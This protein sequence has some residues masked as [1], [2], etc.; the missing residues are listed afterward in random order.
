[1]DPVITTY[2]LLTLS[3]GDALSLQLYRFKGATPGKVVYLQSNLH[4]AEIAGNVV[5]HHLVTYLQTLD[6]QKLQG[7][8][9]LVPSCN[10]LG[11]NTRAHQFSSGRFNPYDGRDWNRIFWDYEHLHQGALPFAQQ[12]LKQDIATIQQAYRQTILEHFQTQLE[13]L[14]S[15]VGVPVHQA[16]RT[17]LQH[18]ALDADIVIDLHTSANQGMV[19]L[20]YFRDRAA[21]IPTFGVDFALML[22]HYDGN[23]FDEAFINPWLSLETAFASLGRPLQFEIDAWTLELGC[24]L[25]INPVAVQRGV[26]GVLNYLRYRGI[27]TDQPAITHPPVPLGCRSRLTKYYATTGGFI[28]NRV[29]LGTWVKAG[30]PL[31]ELLNFNKTGQLPAIL[32]VSAQQAGLVYDLS[33]NQAV[34]EGEYVLAIMM[35][36]P[37]TTS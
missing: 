6:S 5:I 32:S 19:Y 9:R 28:Q 11:V 15:P 22:D 14:Q 31:F 24:G 23:A 16:Y 33:W 35:P 4:G 8:I 29:A 13:A 12:S 21:L 17:R 18:L 1:M 2:P 25:Q 7:E 36:D 3:S 30:E 27:L 20:Y 10:P 34:S 26:A 37:E